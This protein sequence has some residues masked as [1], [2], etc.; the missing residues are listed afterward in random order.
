MITLL[1]KDKLKTVI[2]QLW[3]DDQIPTDAQE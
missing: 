3:S 2:S 1:G